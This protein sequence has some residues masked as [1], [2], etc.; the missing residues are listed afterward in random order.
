MINQTQQDIDKE[1]IRLMVRRM[2]LI[3]DLQEAR[4]LGRTPDA[5]R[6]L[7]ISVL[8]KLGNSSSRLMACS[9]WK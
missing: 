8:S 5:W 6:A 9:G 7:R 1:T 4:I 2:N 3:R